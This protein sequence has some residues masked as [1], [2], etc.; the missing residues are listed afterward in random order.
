MANIDHQVEHMWSRTGVRSW[1]DESGLIKRIEVRC[2]R[3]P[4]VFWYRNGTFVDWSRH[5]FECVGEGTAS[6]RRRGCI[7]WVSGRRYWGAA[8]H[9][10]SLD[11][12]VEQACRAIVPFFIREAGMEWTPPPSLPTAPLCHGGLGGAQSAVL[13]LPDKYRNIEAAAGPEEGGSAASDCHQKL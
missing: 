1:I 4:Y 9:R 10:Y 3:Y 8:G 7:A 11:S 12:A 2:N 5:V 6:G 13:H